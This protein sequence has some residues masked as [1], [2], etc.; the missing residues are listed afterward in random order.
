EDLKRLID[1]AHGRGLMVF[2]DV[3]YNHFGPEGNYLHRIAPE[4]FTDAHTPWGVAINY[5]NP[6]VRAFVI[7]NV[8]HWLEHYRFD[9]LR[10]DAVHA[11]VTR[12]EPEILTDI[13]KAVG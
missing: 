9:G 10:F 13:S 5:A 12:G 1:A 7:E 8:V 11:I 2:L 4:F 3:V 6:N